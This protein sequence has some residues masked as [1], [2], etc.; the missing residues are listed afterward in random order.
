[1]WP[2]VCRKL[3]ASNLF[4]WLFSV[5]E[6]FEDTYMTIWFYY[7]KQISEQLNPIMGIKKKRNTKVVQIKKLFGLALLSKSSFHLH[8]VEFTICCFKSHITNSVH[9][10][11]QFKV[12]I[13]K[14][15]G[16]VRFLCSSL[17]APDKLCRS[18]DF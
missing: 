13:N 14:S 17:T 2:G 3:I 8:P 11:I 4:S 9:R 5:I 16:R 10:Y 18:I 7:P 15:E 1:M 12:I 6:I